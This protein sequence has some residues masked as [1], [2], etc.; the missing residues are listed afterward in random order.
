MIDDHL[1][2]FKHALFKAVCTLSR[3]WVGAPR[4]SLLPAP[5]EHI[6]AP[7]GISGPR[8]FD[9]GHKTEDF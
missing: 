3:A 8:P 2:H 1:L 4:G 5:R 7:R 9:D 6:V